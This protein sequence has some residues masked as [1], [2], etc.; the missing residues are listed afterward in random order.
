MESLIHGP[1]RATAVRPEKRPHHQRTLRSAWQ[2][3]LA[4]L[5]RQWIGWI[6]HVFNLPAKS[7]INGYRAMRISGNHQGDRHQCLTTKKPD[8]AS[9]PN[10]A[11]VFP[12]AA[13]T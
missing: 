1:T 10:R 5:L 2:L 6:H 9:L 7:L 3:A 13:T 4:A 8:P 11:S 12:L